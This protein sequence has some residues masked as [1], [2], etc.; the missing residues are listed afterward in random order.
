LYVYGSLSYVVAGIADTTCVGKP[1]ENA[2]I[3]GTWHRMRTMMGF[4]HGV[5]LWTGLKWLRTEKNTM[6]L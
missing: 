3:G 6:I 5:N 1:D 2:T 4:A